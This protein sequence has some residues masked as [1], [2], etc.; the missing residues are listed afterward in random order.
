MNKI[1]PITIGIGGGSAS[2]KSTICSYIENELINFK[3]H[4]I[5]LDDYYKC[6]KPSVIS[7][8]TKI[9]YEDFNHPDSID[10]KTLIGDL[11]NLKEKDLDVILI[12]GLMVLHKDEI[13]EN[14]DLKLYIDCQSDERLVRRVKRNLQWGQNF[15]EITS[16]YLD[17]V[18]YRHDEFI[19]PSRW[20]ADIVLNGS[21]FSHKGI[22]LVIEWIKNNVNT[23]R[24]FNE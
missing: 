17:S 19:E 3:V 12:E 1:N 16:V 7:P 14:L 22:N 8:F 9:V 5:H 4:S 20:H 11:D 2:G 24:V 13:R 6:K 21:T 15:D 23:R 10:F 18:R